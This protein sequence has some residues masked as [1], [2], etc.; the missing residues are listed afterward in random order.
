MHFKLPNAPTMATKPLYAITN[1][2]AQILSFV[3]QTHFNSLRRVYGL[4]RER[5]RELSEG[6]KMLKAQIVMCLHGKLF[7]SGIC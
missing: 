7:L 1:A 6:L 3:S 4:G 2:I 5:E